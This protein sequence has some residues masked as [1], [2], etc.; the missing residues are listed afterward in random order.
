[1][2]MFNL[3]FI[4]DKPAGPQKI[5]AVMDVL[6]AAFPDVQSIMEVRVI[7]SSGGDGETIMIPLPTSLPQD[8][9]AKIRSILDESLAKNGL[10]KRK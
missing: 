6:V 3:A 5:R 7:P 10:G 2:S 8:R 4:L 9:Q 1:M